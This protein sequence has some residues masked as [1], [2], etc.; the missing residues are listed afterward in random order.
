MNWILWCKLL[1]W[2][3]ARAE[4]WSTSGK[5]PA[6]GTCSTSTLLFLAFKYKE[7]HIFDGE[8]IQYKASSACSTNIDAPAAEYSTNQVRIQSFDRKI[9]LI[10]WLF[11]CWWWWW[12]VCL[13]ISLLAITF[14][15]LYYYRLEVFSLGRR[16]RVFNGKWNR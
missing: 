12:C 13:L 4:W 15:Q 1:L 11:C 2:I 6:L 8:Y 9:D 16:A 5:W 3:R 7:E 14:R 10:D